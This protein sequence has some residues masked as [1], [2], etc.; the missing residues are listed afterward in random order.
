MKNFTLIFPYYR[1]PLMLQFHLEMVWGMY[2]AGIKVIVVD[3]GSPDP[4]RP[5]IERSL[6]QGYCEALDLRLYRITVDL[7]WNREG[8][9]NLGAHVAE[10]EWIVQLDIDHTLA[11]TSAAALLAFKPNP[12]RWYRLTRFRVGEADETRLKDKLPREARYGR[13]KPHIDSYLMRRAAY[14][15]LGGYDEDFVGCLGGGTNFLKRADRAMPVDMLPD[16]I[17]LCV[18]T[19]HSVPDASD[20]HLSRD[21]SRGKEIGRQKEQAGLPRPTNPLRFPWVRER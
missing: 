9:R 8:A 5:V 15:D 19:R 21:T 20:L 2:P 13:V 16:D 18:H 11:P 10:T 12:D 1:N 6:D 7:P 17:S 3:D 4:A 14:L